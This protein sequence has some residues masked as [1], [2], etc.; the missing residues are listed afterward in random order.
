MPESDL[1][2]S[3]ITLLPTLFPR[4]RLC[5][6]L[7][8]LPHCPRKAYHFFPIVC[9]IHHAVHND[10]RS[11]RTL[12]TRRQQASTIVVN[13]S[14]SALSA[15][16]VRIPH[17]ATSLI[18]CPPPSFRYSC[19]LP[20]THPHPERSMRNL[21]TYRQCIHLTCSLLLT[22]YLYPAFGDH[23]DAF[24]PH[25][26][27]ISPGIRSTCNVLLLWPFIHL[28]C[29]AA[30]AVLL[31]AWERFLDMCCEGSRHAKHAAQVSHSACHACLAPRT[32]LFVVGMGR[33]RF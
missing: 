31:H 33:T 23:F 21:V 11:L 12:E 24:T 25:T 10:P 3:T 14:G 17:P 15:L 19:L 9:L 27:P 30:L 32:N 1:R 22:V 20:T 4:P 16:A 6:V 18:R 5:P 13:A 28:G 26:H 7:S 2:S 29:I 8:C